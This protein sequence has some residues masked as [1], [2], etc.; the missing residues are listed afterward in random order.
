MKLV[1]AAI[2]T[3]SLATAGVA[4]A[5][6]D[7]NWLHEKCL[8]GPLP[9]TMNINTQA[10]ADKLI[11]WNVCYGYVLGVL[12]ASSSSVCLI[13]NVTRNQLVAV[14][15]KYLNDHPEKWHFPS[16]KL[17]LEATNNSFCTPQ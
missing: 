16:F 7:G 15:T 2:L 3:V 13:K 11:N 8:A 14:V 12:E 1:S 6:S 4:R 5:E 17:V 10:D 9:E